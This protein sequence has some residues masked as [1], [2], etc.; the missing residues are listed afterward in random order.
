[1]NLPLIFN[2]ALGL[3]FIYLTLSLLASEIQELIATLLQWRAKHLKQAIEILLAGEASPDVIDARRVNA[4]PVTQEQIDRTR[5][6]ASSLYR[7]PLIRSM[8]QE[9]KGMIGKLGQQLSSV[10]GTRQIF[11]GQ[12]SGPSYLPAETFASTL[13]ETL[14]LDNLLQHL[15]QAKLETFIQNRIR[16]PV[17][18][19][20]ADLRHSQATELL[21]EHSLQRL[22]TE[23]D[24]I[25][26]SFR[27]RNLS[28]TGALNQAVAGLQRFKADA[29]AVLPE[30]NYL[31]GIF[32]RR[33]GALE[34]QLPTLLQNA[35]PTLVEVVTALDKMSWVAR[36]LSE[37]Q[38]RYQAVISHLS[39]PALR[40]RFQQGYELLEAVKLLGNKTGQAATDYQ[41]IL[42]K[43]S[44][45]LSESL[46]TLAYRA[47]TKLDSLEQGANQL[48]Q[49]IGTWFDRS[50]DRASGVYKRNAKGVAILLGCALAIATNTDTLYV[51]NKLSRDPAL[52]DAVTTAANQLVTSNPAA[53]SC[54]NL[55]ADAPVAEGSL[56]ETAAPDAAAQALCNAETSRLGRSLLEATSL[57]IGWGNVNP[58]AQWGTAPGPLGI[59]K[60][61]LGW[62]ISGI[63]ISMGA[64]FWFNLLNKLVNVRNTGRP[65]QASD[66]S[67][68]T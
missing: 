19:V 38:G 25:L 2:L 3:T 49:E 4:D 52:L 54:L 66:Q 40:E 55:G 63:A 50:M 17:A 27:D 7:H 5:T 36:N 64:P 37:N 57:P 47:Q 15:T 9:S 58:Q 41:E 22:N 33:L 48:R 46:T 65:P 51:V 67:P 26:Q 32:L 59:A 34:Q 10:T 62:L 14:G 30:E 23:L 6:L 18:D 16:G 68:P 28:F 21:L 11:A 20:L 31:N 13:M 29:G 61:L 39:D 42:A 12:S 45:Y 24:E 35:P 44:P 60:V 53:F 8:N 1:M 56:P 43:V